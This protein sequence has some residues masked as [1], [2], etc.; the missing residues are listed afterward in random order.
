MEK[1]I[2][3]CVMNLNF[4]ILTVLCTLHVCICV[5]VHTVHPI[6][7]ELKSFASFILYADFINPVSQFLFL[8]TLQI[9]KSNPIPNQKIHDLIRSVLR[10]RKYLIFKSSE[11]TDEQEGFLQCQTLTSYID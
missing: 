8:Y 1:A 2:F 5:C 4:S 11:F 3:I 7:A 6:H 9:E 10:L